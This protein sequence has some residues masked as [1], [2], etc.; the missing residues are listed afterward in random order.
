ML[1]RVAEAEGG[2]PSTQPV[3]V[4]Q[5]EVPEEY[6]EASQTGSQTSE[7]H[8]VEEGETLPFLAGWDHD[9]YDQPEQRSDFDLEQELE[10]HK[11]V[12]GYP[13]FSPPVVDA[14]LPASDVSDDTPLEPRWRPRKKG[15]KH[16]TA[17]YELKLADSSDLYDPSL[18]H[19]EW[20]DALD[21]KE[22]IR[23]VNDGIPQWKGEYRIVDRLGEGE[24]FACSF[25]S[26]S[27]AESRPSP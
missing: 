1:D 26:A 15:S 13:M 14:A 24:I 19:Y 2:T 6:F 10:H 12:I 23:K 8:P 18:Q 4:L 25:Q 3:F 27:T 7:Q 21:I 11:L 9:G 5:P 17:S 20:R 16:L 22:D